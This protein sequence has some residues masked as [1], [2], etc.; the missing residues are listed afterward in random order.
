[1]N[2]FFLNG[3][4]KTKEVLYYKLF[5]RENI[6]TIKLVEGCVINQKILYVNICL[7]HFTLRSLEN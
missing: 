2:D 6:F 3:S 5:N 7:L 4:T 1:M